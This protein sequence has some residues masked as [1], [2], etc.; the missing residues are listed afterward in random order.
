ML[1][2]VVCHSL[3]LI[4]LSGFPCF[5]STQP[6]HRLRCDEM[7]AIGRHS[8]HAASGGRT[9]RQAN[10]ELLRGHANILRSEHVPSED[11]VLRRSKDDPTEDCRGK[12]LH[13]GR[14]WWV[15]CLGLVLVLFCIIITGCFSHIVPTDN[16]ITRSELCEVEING[17]ITRKQIGEKWFSMV[18]RTTCMNFECLRGEASEPFVNSIGITC[19]SQCPE[20]IYSYRI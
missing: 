13:F 1:I 12:V 17:T 18:N 10:G 6:T 9:H 4:I 2:V 3:K 11:P 14:V 5:Y 8:G 7:P 16:N 15:E 19:N 20:V